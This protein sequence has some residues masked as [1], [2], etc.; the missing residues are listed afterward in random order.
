MQ[1]TPESKSVLDKLLTG[2]T[3]TA[4]EISVGPF[5]E[6]TQLL[7]QV[8]IDYYDALS[9]SHGEEQAEK[10]VKAYL[11]A[12]EPET[13][14]IGSNSEP[15]QQESTESTQDMRERETSPELPT[16]PTLDA[17]PRWKLY[18][19]N[20]RSIK[21]V[22]APGEEFPFFFDGKSNLL[23]GPNGSGKSSLLGAVMWVLTG[24]TL[25]DD[26]EQKDVASIHRTSEGAK[27]G[28]KIRDWPTI[29]TLPDTNDP[30]SAIPDSMA[31]IELKSW[32][33]KTAIYFH[34]TLSEGL[35]VSTD[36]EV[37]TPCTDLSIYA[38]KPLD[39]Q[40]SIIAPTIFGRQ[41]IETAPD[42]RKIL[43]LMLGYDPLEDIGSLVSNLARNRTSLFN[44][45]TTTT[46]SDREKLSIKVASLGALLPDGNSLKEE[47]KALQ[48]HAKLSS[49]TIEEMS[50]KV[51]DQIEGSSASLGTILGIMEGDALVSTDLAENLI[52]AI[53]NLE[54]GFAEVW[55]SLSAIELEVVL[56]Q[57]GDVGFEQQFA[58]LQ[59]D[60]DSFTSRAQTTIAERL[61]WWRK[62]TEPGSKA[63]L[64]LL[65]AKDYYDPSKM[66]CPVCEQSIKDRPVKNELESLKN[67]DTKLLEDVKLFFN[68]LEE[69]LENTIPHSLRNVSKDQ[70]RERL[71]KDWGALK[72]REELAE[73]ATIIQRFESRVTELGAAICTIT[74]EL[75]QLLPPDAEPAFLRIASSLISKVN[76]AHRALAILQWASAELFTL[77]EKLSHLVTAPVEKNASSLLAILS[78]GKSA[79]QEIEPLKK[80]EGELSEVEIAN[81]K[82]LKS[83]A[84]L[85]I[86]ENLKGPLDNLKNISKYAVEKTTTIFA[87]IKDKAIE[88]WKLL[89]PEHST[90]I[91]PSRLVM[92]GGR[93]KSI[94]SLLTHGDYEVPGPP[95]ANAGLQ[96][97]IALSFLCAL[98]DKHPNGL[99][100]VIFD[101]PILSLDDDHRESWSGK[102]LAPRMQTT[103]VILATHQR[104]FIDNC[105][106]DFA[107]GKI[108]ELNPRDEKQRISWMPGDILDQAEDMLRTNW[109]YVPNVLRQYR[110]GILIT[111]QAYSQDDFFS[112]H[113]S[114]KSLERYERL[115]DTNPLVGA[116]QKQIVAGLRSPEIERV[117]DPGSHALTQK[118]ITKPMVQ[119]CF[120][121]LRKPLNNIFL[122]E[123][124]RLRCLRTRRMRGNIIPTSTVSFPDVPKKA[125][126]ANPFLL[127]VIG[128]AAARQESWVLDS[129]GEVS[130]TT[131]APYTAVFVLGESLNPVI[132][133][134]QCALLA[135]DDIQPDDD[136]LVAVVSSDGNRYLR[137]L[138]SDGEGNILQAIHP[139]RPVPAIRSLADVT[140]MRKV[141]GVLYKPALRPN[142]Q[143]SSKTLEWYPYSNFPSKIIG[144][145]KT[146]TVEGDSLDPIARKGQKV[147][148]GER[149]SAKDTTVE[150]GG[151]AALEVED[152]TIGNVIKRVYRKSGV[153]TLVSPNPVVPYTPDI[154][155][156][157]K[158][159]GVWPL[160]GV[161][162]DTMD[163]QADELFSH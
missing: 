56:P 126:F 136:D 152:E 95:F 53:G 50:N 46:N 25:T 142:M 104:Q 62:E 9:V 8:I 14:E 43:S 34:R 161:L 80:L 112:P 10:L 19:L 143:P 12:V 32:D 120:R 139:T 59:E 146:L 123:I 28:S 127:Q 68:N 155:P 128:R 125:V 149:E 51:T 105:K 150:N 66:E 124:E 94:G 97:A 82:I 42:S 30:S 153:W 154:V 75:P 131:F 114:S 18:E 63:K 115:P 108:V 81:K 70:P 91:Y 156:M 148:V 41:A 48:S 33:E 113:N 98:L 17:P 111:L 11:S 57:K 116:K 78:K 79:A 107:S 92:A 129:S 37:W 147:L 45:L 109:K 3:M 144:D 157:D 6:T 96:R 140:A 5:D 76:S 122:R 103:Q 38:I 61:E 13:K 117:L 159:I 121:K 160:R 35:E 15:S 84:K 83:Q 77:K 2:E 1:V 93:D 20:C 49:E 71:L 39:L 26:P 23:F 4:G 134:G 89:Y 16:I 27:R 90:G 31:T 145:L 135:A 141:V 86:L 58:K 24:L 119:E 60:L 163:D 69:G 137:K 36:K 54:K 99:G 40:L 162:F 55:P 21:G 87:E 101:D 130:S 88:N 52:K 85:K 158:I 133:N 7:L 65:A 100:F 151:L 47:I 102:I 106:D 118:D 110:E 138:W 73:L 72:T 132:R 67:L 74:P 29:S 22:A 64:L 44:N